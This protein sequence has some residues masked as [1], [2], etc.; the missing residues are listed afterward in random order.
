[1]KHVLILL[2]LTLALYSSSSTERMAGEL[3]HISYNQKEVM[4]RAY[5]KG[6]N[7]DL[8]Y[9]LAAIAWNESNFGKF[10]INTADGNN[11]KYKGSYGV[12]HVLLNSAMGREGSKS[13]WHASSVAEKLYTDMDYCVD[14][15]LIELEFWNRVWRDKGVDRVYS[16]TI[17]SYNAGYK[18]LDSRYGT[19]YAI[20]L[21]KRVRVLKKYFKDHNINEL[22]S[23]E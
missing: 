8:G 12:Y 20:L 21:L 5:M 1:M 7:S 18:S 14:K 19:E 6:R 4:I 13:N 16:H 17:A 10:N 9:T 22:L 2:M 11:L 3:N 15:A 23:K